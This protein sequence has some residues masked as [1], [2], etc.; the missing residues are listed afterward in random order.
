L[1]YNQ[2]F[3]HL[4]ASDIHCH[5]NQAPAHTR[6]SV[7]VA[8]FHSVDILANCV[9]TH[10]LAAHHHNLANRDQPLAGVHNQAVAAILG[11][12]SH[13]NSHILYCGVCSCHCNTLLAYCLVLPFTHQ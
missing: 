5:N 4:V 11:K 3:I 8:S 7:G 9:C 2:G 10:H 12:A 6:V 13:T 1:V